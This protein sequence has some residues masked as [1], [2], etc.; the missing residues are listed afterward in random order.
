MYVG[1]RVVPWF[2]VDEFRYVLSNLKSRSIAD[3]HKALLFTQIWLSRMDHSKVPRAIICTYEL[4]LAR[5]QKSTQALAVAVMRF[6]SFVSSEDQ[7]RTRSGFAIPICSL[8]ANVGLPPW[9]SYLRN[10]IAHGPMPSEDC[11]E[12]AYDFAMSWLLEFW[13][14]N[15]EDTW[16]KPDLGVLERINWSSSRCVIEEFLACPVRHVAVTQAYADHLVKLANSGYRSLANSEVKSVLRLFQKFHRV[17]DLIYIVYTLFPTDGAVFWANAWLEAFK[18][19]VGSRE[20]SLL[21]SYSRLDLSAFPWRQCLEQVCLSSNPANFDL[22]LFL[23]LFQPQLPSEIRSGLLAICCSGDVS[24]P[25]PTNA[26][27]YVKWRLDR[28][29]RWWR[30]PLGAAFSMRAVS[31]HV[32]FPFRRCRN[33]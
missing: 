6:I 25:E 4:L 26:E 14:S 15:V 24:L 2:S 12:K 9:M 22:T 8:A 1:S 32:L 29:V 16:S 18:A 11:L 3:L 19:L 33:K 5:L 21:E 13:E 30:V 27:F 28:S 23:E 7:D 20:H 17:N 31:Y 10:E